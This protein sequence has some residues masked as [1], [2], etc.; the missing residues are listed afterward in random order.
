MDLMGGIPPTGSSSH[1]F[2]YHFLQHFPK[3]TFCFE[4]NL[5][6]KNTQKWSSF[7]SYSVTLLEGSGIPSFNRRSSSFKTSL[8][9][10]F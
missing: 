1:H 3:R 10:I 6:R 7:E 4:A 5:S 8:L 9:Q 2:L